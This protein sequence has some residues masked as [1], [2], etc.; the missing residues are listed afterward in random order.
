MS[1]PWDPEI[2]YGAL[3]KEEGECSEVQ[4]SSRRF[5]ILK[6]KGMKLS[7]M[8]IKEALYRKQPSSIY[9]FVFVFVALEREYF[10]L[11]F[12]FVSLL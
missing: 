12:L 9:F 6:E 2:M 1:T 5:P 7:Y 3:F 4:V 10:L 11:C 8:A